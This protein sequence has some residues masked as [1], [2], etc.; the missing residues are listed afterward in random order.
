MKA[1]KG[2]LI[3]LVIFSSAILFLILIVRSCNKNIE[4]KFEHYAGN[5]K[6]D[7][8]FRLNTNVSGYYIKKY[9]ISLDPKYFNHGPKNSEAEVYFENFIPITDSTLKYKYLLEFENLDDT[10]YIKYG[11]LSLASIYDFNKR[12]WLT[13]SDSL[14]PNAFENFQSFFKENVLK[15]VIQQYKDSVPSNLLFRNKSDSIILRKLD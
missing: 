15:K 14:A 8:D 3:L 2:V 11:G 4:K 7:I 1:H 12:Q 5:R 10:A 6:P 13:N 9:I